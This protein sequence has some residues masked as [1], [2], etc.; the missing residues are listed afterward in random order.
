MFVPRLEQ[1]RAP[2]R[3]HLP[4][5]DLNRQGLELIRVTRDLLDEGVYLLSSVATLLEPGGDEAGR[6]LQARV[7][8]RGLEALAADSWFGAQRL[9]GATLQLGRPALQLQ[10]PELAEVCEGL[11]L[12]GAEG[13]VPGALEAAR[14]R[15]LAS[16]EAL[17]SAREE[18]ESA[19]MRLRW[20]CG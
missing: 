4:R 3:F 11:D 15:V 9:S 14:A 5:R 17:Q 12:T 13:G 16:L 18:C 10:V 2:R 1:R 19:A 8:L 7:L 6:L 20:R